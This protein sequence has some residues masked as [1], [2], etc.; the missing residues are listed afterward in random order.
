MVLPLIM[1]MVLPKLINAQDP[2]T[3]RVNIS[4]KVENKNIIKYCTLSLTL[5]QEMQSQMNFFTPK[6]NMPEISEFLTNLL[7]GGPKKPTQSRTKSS[8]RR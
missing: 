2:E 7:S 5:F 4:H 3:Q 6:N 8:K 1:V